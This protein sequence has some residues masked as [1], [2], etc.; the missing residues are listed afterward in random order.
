MLLLFFLL[1]IA[2]WP[3]EAQRWIAAFFNQ[4][5]L[6]RC[7]KLFDNSESSFV[8]QCEHHTIVFN[9]PSL[10]PYE[11]YFGEQQ[12]LRVLAVAED[13]HGK[14]LLIHLDEG[15]LHT[16]N[17]FP[18]VTVYNGPRPYGAVY[19]NVC[20]GLVLVLTPILTVGAMGT[21]CS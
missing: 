19:S 7:R 8:P 15:N 17:Q 13:E 1:F 20:G 21:I 18:H 14:A 3:T 6:A 2:V 11:E 5:E 12:L 16:T 9:P 4:S 10:G